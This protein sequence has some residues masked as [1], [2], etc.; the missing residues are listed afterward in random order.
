MD[1]EAM[2]AKAAGKNKKN[3]SI[4]LILIILG[5]VPALVVMIS[6]FLIAR[7][8]LKAGMEKK[9][10]DGIEMMANAVEAAFH[11][12]P[13]EYSVNADGDLLKGEVNLTETQF[14]AIDK[15]VAGSN[16]D[17]TL[18]YG[19]TRMIT[20]LKDENGQRNVGTDI[21]DE[22]WEV[23][24]RG[25]TYRSSNL[26]VNGKDYYAC[27]VPVRDDSGVIIG[28]ISSGES[29][30]DV[31]ALVQS[32]VT[33]IMIVSVIIIIIMGVAAFFLA[34]MIAKQ[35][36]KVEKYVEEVAGGDL[37]IV[38][39]EKLKNRNDEIGRMGRAVE[40]LVRELKKVVGSLQHSADTLF[41]AG[42]TL[43]EMSSQSS[44]TADEISR[45][46]EDVSKGAVS[47]ADEI[48]SA[49]SEVVT[50]GDLIERIVGNVENLARTS[51]KMSEAGE[52][53]IKTMRELVDANTHTVEAI[54]KI[55]K[56]IRRTN[57][58]VEQISTAASLITNIAEQTSLLSLNASIES[59]RAGEAGKGFAVV[60]GEIQKLAEQSDETA[61]EI[62][63]I[64]DALQDESKETIEVMD[65][66][67][68][69]IKAQQQK[70]DDTRNRFSDVSN[71]INESR[72]ETNIIRDNA[73]AC[74]SARVT[75]VDVITNLSAISEQNA[76]SSQ[77]TTASMQ[78][79]NATINV[80]AESASKLKDLS[81]EL[82]EEMKFFK[83]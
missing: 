20:T 55:A 23:I 78:E 83:V 71:G 28:T 58:S 5:V 46:V 31:D 50:M 36:V 27:Y 74:D 62:M 47:Q 12:Y 15:F 22:V 53:S 70:L 14:E 33:E 29:A 21:S 75:V 66:T 82:N 30:E 79:L 39:D 44:S 13:G 45:A 52:A 6:T 60:A 9:A 77:E 54:N 49:S 2:V 18:C 7:S 80:L 61:T 26:K 35:I 32:K 37:T 81:H 57:E 64:I 73:S 40:K 76:A 19:K 63:R 34:G 43:D 17:I 16:A 48:E 59:A 51:D 10:L 4:R 25:E 72:G 11:L 3:G 67:E 65:R 24:S 1:N 38:V 8:S 42:N 56:Q 41:Q 69:L 68:E